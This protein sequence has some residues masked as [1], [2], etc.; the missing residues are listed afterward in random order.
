MLPALNEISSTQA[1][2]TEYTKEECQQL[3]DYAA[4]YPNVYVQYHASDMVLHVDSNAAYLVLWQARSRIA[5]YFQLNDHPQ[6]VEHLAVNGAILIECK[7][8]WYMVASAA[9]CETAGVFHNI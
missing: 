1:K 4:T 3:M 8:L 7:A 2:P 6:C 5:G 9:E